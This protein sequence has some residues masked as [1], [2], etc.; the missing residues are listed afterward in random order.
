MDGENVPAEGCLWHLP[1]RYGVADQF[2]TTRWFVKVCAGRSGNKVSG[3]R[4]AVAEKN[5]RPMSS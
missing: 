5:S 3:A 1:F 4:V 2:F